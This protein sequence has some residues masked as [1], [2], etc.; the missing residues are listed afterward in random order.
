MK[1]D[2]VINTFDILYNDGNLINNQ[3]TE[4][5]KTKSKEEQ[6]RINKK[7]IILALLNGNRK[8]S[9][10]DRRL[11]SEL[12]SLDGACVVKKNRYLIAI[13]TIIK[14]DAGSSGGGRSA[15]AKKLSKYGMAIKISTDGYVECYYNEKVFYTIK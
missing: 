15:A 4:E 11:R 13:G 10:I 12:I 2:N 8:F 1:K 5:E 3:F 7:T 6:K 9:R 14:I